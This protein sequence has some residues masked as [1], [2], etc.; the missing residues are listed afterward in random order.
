[1]VNVQW[2]TKIDH[3][4]L[5][6]I[7]YCLL[8]QINNIQNVYLFEYVQSN[9][10]LFHWCFRNFFPVVFTLT[11]SVVTAVA[12]DFCLF[13]RQFPELCTNNSNRFFL[14]VANGKIEIKFLFT[15]KTLI[16]LM[17][18]FGLGNGRWSLVIV[19]VIENCSTSLELWVGCSIV[20]SSSILLFTVITFL[21]LKNNIYLLV[22]PD[23][24]IALQN[25]YHQLRLFQS[26]L[27]SLSDLPFHLF[28]FQVEF[29]SSL[30][31]F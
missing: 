29:L 27:H 26:H 4:V 10:L 23:A 15:M 3:F 6:F 1:M 28:F 17:D 25:K 11:G 13:I 9:V 19:I 30:A 31:F 16:I 22:E 14:S 18:F 12:I 8:K 7:V 5:F 24:S 2:I 20:Q 21:R